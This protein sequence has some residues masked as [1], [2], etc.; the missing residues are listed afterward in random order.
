MFQKNEIVGETPTDHLSSLSS[1]AIK[2]MGNNSFMKGDYAEAL[3]FFTAAIENCPPDRSMDLATFYQ[4]R[5]ATFERLGDLQNVLDDCSSAV[6]LNK[7]YVKA[8]LRRGKANRA[9]GRLEDAL[10]DFSCAFALQ[11]YRDMTT[12]R[13]TDQL[14]NDYAAAKAK[15]LMSTRRLE[16][17]PL[18]NSFVESYLGTYAE[19]PI[20]TSFDAVK[21]RVQ[22]EPKLESW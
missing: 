6:A 16:E 14:M 4:N 18:S 13:M 5:A 12:F 7:R 3:K 10:Y 17:L 21:L 1:A 2:E 9:L 19:D 22:Q 15:E 11:E 8:L 20:K